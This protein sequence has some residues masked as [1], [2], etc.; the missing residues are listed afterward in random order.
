MQYAPETHRDAMMCGKHGEQKS[1]LILAGVSFCETCVRDALL[2]S[3]VT[4][5]YFERITR[6][7]TPQ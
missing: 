4:P 5:I 1:T 6:T 7:P 3:G 2:K